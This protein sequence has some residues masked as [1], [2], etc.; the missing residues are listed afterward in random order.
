M[1]P[2]PKE[3]TD[4]QIEQ[5]RAEATAGMGLGAKARNMNSHTK[6]RQSRGRTMI[7]CTTDQAYELIIYALIRQHCRCYASGL[8]LLVRGN[9]PKG[10]W[11]ILTFSP[12]RID[13]DHGYCEGNLR[14]V[15]QFMNDATKGLTDP[16]LAAQLQANM[17]QGFDSW[18]L[19]TEPKPENFSKFYV[20]PDLWTP[21]RRDLDL[22]NTGL[23]HGPNTNQYHTLRSWVMRA[24]GI[25]PELPDLSPVGLKNYLA[26]PEWNSFFE[27]ST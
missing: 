9:Q 7:N 27:P 15:T 18:S 4:K 6:K 23:K 19:P 14:I 12:D 21:D 8:P 16:D 2:R 11:V 5:Q 25:R 1:A 10:A 13:D 26:R 24:F 22:R 20:N 3:K 17:A